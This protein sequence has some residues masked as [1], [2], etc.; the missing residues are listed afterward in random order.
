MGVCECGT[1]RKKTLTADIS[2]IHNHEKCEINRKPRNRHFIN[3]FNVKCMQFLETT[4]DY[5]A[6]RQKKTEFHQQKLLHNVGR[7]KIVYWTG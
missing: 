3:G 1:E 7:E 4:A 2:S 5:K 6:A